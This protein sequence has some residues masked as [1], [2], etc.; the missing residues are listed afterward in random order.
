MCVDTQKDHFWYEVKAYTYG[1]KSHSVAHGRLETFEDIERIWEI[2]QELVSEHGEVLR[3]S[4]L[5]IDRRGY[6]QDGVNRTKQVDEWV[7]KMI[8]KYK[9]G[10]EN[11][12]YPTEGEPKITGDLP[13][14]VI[15]RKDDSDSY[16]KVD[17]K[18]LKLSNLYLKTAIRGAMQNT[19]NFKK[20]QTEEQKAE[21]ED[22]PMFF[23][24]QTTIEA[25]TKGTTSISYT[26]Q[27]SAE[28]Y[29]YGYDKSGKKKNEKEFINP[30]HTDN[31]YFDTSVICE[32]FAQQ[33]QI[34]MMKKPIKEDLSQVLKGLGNLTGN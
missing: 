22:M 5:G 29:D 18:V 12:I 33:D 24:N 27:I 4:K 13:Y 1:N 10:D 23:V 31:H 3:I 26:R 6:N 11:R 8:K 30:K 17:I 32:G 19:I 28:V 2:G 15:T 9:I 34:Y 20:A 25:D 21:F 7:R 14:R 16:I